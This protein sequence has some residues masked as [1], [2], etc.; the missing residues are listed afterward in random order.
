LGMPTA[1]IGEI[2]FH[3]IRGGGISKG[4]Y[5]FNG[6]RIE[7][8]QSTPGKPRPTDFEKVDGHSVW[9]A[10]HVAPETSEP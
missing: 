6:D 1:G 8:S 9:S 10:T 4:I 3:M 5:R 7:V 2:D